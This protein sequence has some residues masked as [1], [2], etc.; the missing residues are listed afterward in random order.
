MICAV[1]GEHAF[2]SG[3]AWSAF[4]LHGDVS[5]AG[6][7]LEQVECQDSRSVSHSSDFSRLTRMESQQERGA[8]S[9]AP[10]KWERQPPRDRSPAPGEAFRLRL[11]IPPARRVAGQRVV[12]GVV[13]DWKVAS[14]S[15]IR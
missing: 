10:R 3:F 7:R 14:N 11:V 4:D 5:L 12:Q 9:Q 8:G 6:E 13:G 1:D 15:L 2:P